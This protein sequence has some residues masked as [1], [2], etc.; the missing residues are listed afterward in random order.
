MNMRL[1]QYYLRLALFVKGRSPVLFLTARLTKRAIRL[2]VRR[3]LVTGAVILWLLALF[4][5]TFIP[6]L[7]EYEFYLWLFFGISVTLIFIA[8]F[9]YSAD[10]LGKRYFDRELRVLNEVKLELRR[11]TANDQRLI[12][13]RLFDRIREQRDVYR[14]LSIHMRNT[15]NSNERSLDSM[16][17]RISDLD[18]EK[19]RIEGLFANYREDA[20]SMKLRI[21]DLD[22]EKTR[23]EELVENYREDAHSMKLR[24]SDLDAEKTRIEE[25]VENH[26][27]DNSSDYERLSEQLKDSI[28]FQSTM[29]EKMVNLDAEK[30][31][32]EEL[33]TDY[34][35]E[36]KTTSDQVLSEVNG[37]TNSASVFNFG[38]YQ[39]INRKLSDSHILHLEH[40]WAKRLNIRTNNRILGYIAHRICMVENLSKGRLATKIQDAVLRVLVAM[41]VKR[42]SIEVL[43]IGSLFGVGLSAIHDRCKNR[44]QSIH[45][46]MVDPLFGYYEKGM[47][48]LQTDEMANEDIVRFNFNTVGIPTD[49]YTI[50][51]GMSTDD[52]SISLASKRT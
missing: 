16:K 19:T 15:A 27:E 24:I 33:V 42:D 17:L 2:C 30:T 6:T 11:Q 9:I 37:I 44:F 21:S 50:I 41:A 7:T 22:A 3:R 49:D 52:E 28:E 35:K 14:N 45:I 36:I 23:I 8:G 12:E 1:R 32:I 31:R 43:E 46:T 20:N 4:V 38:R 29:D 25:L 10:V 26:K 48:D 47:R 34:G 39:P 51:Q 40:D 5:A 13:R 18:A